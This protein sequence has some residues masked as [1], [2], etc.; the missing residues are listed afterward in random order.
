MPSTQEVSHPLKRC[1]LPRADSRH[2]PAQFVCC[3]RNFNFC[4][5]QDPMLARS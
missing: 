4:R 3:V 5:S 2:L 1:Y